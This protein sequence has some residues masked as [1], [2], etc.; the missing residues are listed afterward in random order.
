MKMCVYMYDEE[1]NK[2]TQYSVKSIGTI[3]NPIFYY[4]KVIPGKVMFKNSPCSVEIIQEE[5]NSINISTV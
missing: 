1:R 3:E 4:G 5:E 2:D